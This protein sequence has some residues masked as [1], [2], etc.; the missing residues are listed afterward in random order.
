MEG[1]W[2][3]TGRRKLKCFER[4]LPRQKVKINA[5]RCCEKPIFE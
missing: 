4:N 1:R 2:L 5:Y 3:V